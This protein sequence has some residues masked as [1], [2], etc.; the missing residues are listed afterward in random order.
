VTSAE[1][2]SAKSEGNEWPLALSMFAT[3]LSVFSSSF[4]KIPLPR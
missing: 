4:L 1:A 3:P 2:K